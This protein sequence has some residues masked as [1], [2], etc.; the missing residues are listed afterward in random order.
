MEYELSVKWQFFENDKFSKKYI[1]SG[2]FGQM[3]IFRKK[4]SIKWIFG[5]TTLCA[6]FFRSNDHFLKK[7]KISHMTFRSY[8]DSTEWTFGQMVFGQTVFRSNGLSIKKFRSNDFYPEPSK[9]LKTINSANYYIFD[10][11]SIDFIVFLGL[12]IPENI[13]WAKKIIPSV[14]RRFLLNTKCILC[15]AMVSCP[16]SWKLKSENWGNKSFV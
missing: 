15:L 2:P 14:K 7:Q 3:T 5:Q 8:G 6:I 4:L 11:K 16:M 10:T 12:F 13:N 9:S 1:R